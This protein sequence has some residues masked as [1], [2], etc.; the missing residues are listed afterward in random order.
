MLPPL[1]WPAAYL[2]PQNTSN[3]G[4]RTLAV[5]SSRSKFT[6]RPSGINPG[7]RER[8][9]WF[10]EFE[11]MAIWGASWASRPL[12]EERGG[13][14]TKRAP[15]VL[16]YAPGR[17]VGFHNRTAGGFGLV[18]SGP[19][20]KRITRPWRSNAMGRSGSSNHLLRVSGT[21]SFPRRCRSA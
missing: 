9:W 14:R 17:V 7:V 13:T 18:R 3:F 6:L 5:P 10:W 21:C 2:I 8:Y 4:D 16:H 12:D 11:M 20:G 19:W 15:H 1:A